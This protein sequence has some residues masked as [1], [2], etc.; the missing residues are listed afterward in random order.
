M[1]KERKPGHKKRN[2]V[3]LA[4]LAVLCVGGAELIA[5]RYFA[6]A[7]YEQ[8]TAPVRQGM[9]A[10]ARLGRQVALRAS[11]VWVELTTREEEDDEPAEQDIQLAS[12]PAVDHEVPVSDPSVTELKL[13]HGQE[14]LTG[15]LSTTVYFHQGDELWASQP[16]GSD[17]IGGYGCGP[18]AMAMAVATLTG[19]DTD[20]ASMAQ[21]A[22][23][24]GHWARKSG[25]YLS[26]VEGTASAYGLQAETFSERTPE[27]LR[28]ALLSGKM[29]VALMGPGHFT[30]KGHFILLRGVTLSGMILVAD[31]NSRERSLATWDPQLILDELSSS[32]SNGAPLWT[33]SPATP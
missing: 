33:L 16:Y 25:S 21:W 30:R 17:H 20:P 4:V 8:V 12:E 1:K 18:T 7:L 15:G 9:A 31:P 26:I 14:V 24:H 10:A 28:E 23:Q 32:T 29:L 11:Q 27:A 2:I 5:C 3:L 19:Q 13:S 22:V 6:P